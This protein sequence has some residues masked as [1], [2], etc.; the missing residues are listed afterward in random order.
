MDK[1]EQSSS[2]SRTSSG[3]KE[4]VLSCVASFVLVSNF[5]PHVICAPLSLSPSLPLLNLRRILGGRD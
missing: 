5:L 3:T 4:L 1:T 2:F